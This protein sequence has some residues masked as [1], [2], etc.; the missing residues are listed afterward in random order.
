MPLQEIDNIIINKIYINASNPRNC[1]RARF[2]WLTVTALPSLTCGPERFRGRHCLA[3][4][5]GTAGAGQI[6]D[7]VCYDI[8]M[9]NDGNCETT[10]GGNMFN[11][12]FPMDELHPVARILPPAA[13]VCS[14]APLD[15]GSRPWPGKT[16]GLF[17][18]MKQPE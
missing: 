18:G 5:V 3:D 11:G 15:V 8:V 10:S 13:I 12:A 4:V 1:T 14:W 6:A 2:K 7:L 16:V 9:F 17:H